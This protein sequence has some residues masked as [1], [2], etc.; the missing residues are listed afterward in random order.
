MH[1]MMPPP[2]IVVSICLS[3]KVGKESAGEAMGFVSCAR[4]MVHC[5]SAFLVTF[6]SRTIVGVYCRAK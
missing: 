5:L 1:Q 4:S 2:I 3:G 6:T